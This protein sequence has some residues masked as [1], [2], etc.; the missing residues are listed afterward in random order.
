FNRFSKIKIIVI[1]YESLVYLLMKHFL[2]VFL[3]V[4]LISCT[5]EK[6]TIAEMNADDYTIEWMKID[7]DSIKGSDK[8]YELIE[9]FIPKDK[10]KDTLFDQIKFYSNGKL[11]IKY[12]KYYDLEVSATEKKT[13]L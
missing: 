3:V 12:S 10:N 7:Y 4:F 5:K 1:S 2:V 11:N 9:L 8:N 13:R 6:D